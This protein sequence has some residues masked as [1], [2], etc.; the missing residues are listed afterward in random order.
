MVARSRR[1]ENRLSKCPIATLIETRGVW[2]VK[3]TRSAAARRNAD[4]DFDREKRVAC[5]RNLSRK[6][7]VAVKPPYFG[8]LARMP[9]DASKRKPAVRRRSA[10]FVPHVFALDSR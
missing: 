7:E 2:V 3:R 8:L 5:S 6:I 9:N 4:R 10:A 1:D